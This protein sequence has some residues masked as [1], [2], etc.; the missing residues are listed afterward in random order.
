LT[1]QAVPVQQESTATGADL[2]G[3]AHT[4]WDGDLHRSTA[5][6]VLPAASSEPRECGAPRRNWAHLGAR[7][8]EERQDFWIVS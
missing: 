8:I 6:D 5:V 4:L 7:V 1:G 3:R 2:T